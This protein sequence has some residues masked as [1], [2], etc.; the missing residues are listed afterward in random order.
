MPHQFL[1]S[2]L[3]STARNHEHYRHLLPLLITLGESHCAGKCY[4]CFL[5][6]ELNLLYPI[7]ERRFRLLRSFQNN[8]TFIKYKLRRKTV[9]AERSLNNTVP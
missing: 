9:L 5:M 4:V 8:L 1:I 3:R 6:V 7:R 2:I